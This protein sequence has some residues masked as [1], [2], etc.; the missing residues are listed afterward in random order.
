MASRIGNWG[1]CAW[2]ESLV[3]GF[4]TGFADAKIG[5]RGTMGW[6]RK[7]EMRDDIR[8]FLDWGGELMLRK[9]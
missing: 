2:K 4:E 3:N 1:L 5:C 7:C 6:K 8:G 9:H